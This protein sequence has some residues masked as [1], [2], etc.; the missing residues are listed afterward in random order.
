MSE[1]AC[2]EQVFD[3]IFFFRR[4]AGE[5]APAAPLGPVG[6]SRH[7]FHI[8]GIR[9]RHDDLFILNE[10]FHVK[11]FDSGLDLRS[12]LVSILFF[13]RDE[14]F[15]NDGHH[16]F[17]VGQNAFEPRDCFNE[18]FVFLF[19]RLSFEVREL[20]ESHVQ[21]GLSLDLRKLKLSH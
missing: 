17:G 6:V 3:K 9:Q 19:Q 7:P 1:R 10:V 15:L 16:F 20:V 13:N 4:H 12:A 2:D 21:N 5:A 18:L 11:F 8:T 14:F